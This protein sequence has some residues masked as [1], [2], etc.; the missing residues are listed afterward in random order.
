MRVSH[1]KIGTR[2][3]FAF[4]TMIVLMGVVAAA[5]VVSMF[6]VKHDLDAVAKVNNAKLKINNDLIEQVHVIQRVTRTLILLDDPEVKKREA[7]K[8][9]EARERYEALW[10][11]LAEFAPTA[12]GAGLRAAIDGAR[13]AANGVN[14]KILILALA[15]RD[16]EARELLLA[17]GIAVNQKWVD[18]VEANIKYQ[19]ESNERRVQEADAAVAQGIWAVGAIALCAAGL[20]IFAGWFITGSVVRPIRYASDCALRMAGGDLTVPVERRKGF[21]GRDETSQLISAM[22]TMHDSFS[23]MV[24][25]VHQN[26]ASVSAAAQQIATGNADL[27]MRTEQQAA[28]LEQTAATMDELTATVRGNADSTVQAVELAS[29]AGRVAGR[30]G[31][32]MQ[33]VVVTMGAIDRSSKKIADIIGVIDGIAF[34]TNIL[35]LNAAVE[36]ARAGEQGRGFAVV[37]AEVRSLAQRSGEAAREIKTL[38]NASVEQV[39]AG[40]EL[41][42]RAGATMA[43]IVHSIDRVNQLMG[44]IRTATTEQTDGITQ[45]GVAVADMD[46]GTQQNAALVEQSAAAAESLNQQARQL[47]EK[48]SQFKLAAC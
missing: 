20:G 16:D 36:A 22:Q 46:R 7:V 3:A 43:E 14:G 26:A 28:S 45:V 38:I 17:E 13:T 25:S 21:D 12:A 37:A 29:G 18:A 5:G 9:R 47:M 27:S 44:E 41:V 2:L 40:T 35:A 15:N 24:A 10:A 30:G 32:V 48:V 4:G 31:E 23:A 33:Q 8:I 19:E 6:S 39:S 1:I 42:E 11:T 34:Q